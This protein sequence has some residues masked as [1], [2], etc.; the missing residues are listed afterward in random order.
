MFRT[1]QYFSV[2]K[3]HVEVKLQKSTSISKISLENTSHAISFTF[4]GLYILK[5]YQQK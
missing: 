4:R 1:A 3:D 2:Q 5:P